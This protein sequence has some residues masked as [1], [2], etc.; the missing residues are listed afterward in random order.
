MNIENLK[1][2]VELLKTIPQSSFG[3]AT[4]RDWENDKG[5]TPECKSVGCIIGHATVLDRENVLKNYV[6]GDK[7][8]PTILFSSWSHDF[9]GIPA[10]Y[11]SLWAYLFSCTWADDERTNTPEH[12]VYRIQKV[13]DGYKP[14]LNHIEYANEID[15][16]NNG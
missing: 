7:D 10:A 4:Y 15:R 12:A 16:L 1:R 13:I 3:M 5:F 6:S 14:I 9:F 2:T 8:N 11:L